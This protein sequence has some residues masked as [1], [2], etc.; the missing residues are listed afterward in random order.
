MIDEV[1][2]TL[3]CMTKEIIMG[4]KMNRKKEVSSLQLVDMALALLLLLF[5]SSFIPFIHHIYCR[6]SYPSAIA[7]FYAFGIFNFSC[8]EKVFLFVL[9]KIKKKKQQTECI[10]LKW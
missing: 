10:L 5:L 8:P 4:R 7:H 3:V 6:P 9:I 1:H 2:E